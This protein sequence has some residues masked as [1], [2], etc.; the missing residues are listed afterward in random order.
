M[1]TGF[2]PEC[3]GKY[4]RQSKKVSATFSKLP[5]PRQWRIAKII[6]LKKPNKDN[7]TQAK[8]WRP[9]SLL[10]TVGKLLEAVIAERISFAVETHG[11]LPTNHFGARKQ[12]SAEQALLL[13]QEHIY[14]AWRGKNVLSLLSFDVKGAYNGVCKDSLL[15]RLVA[16][17]IPPDVVN[18][19]D[20]FC[21]ER[22]ATIVVNGRTSELSGLEQAGL[23]QG[24]P[25]SPILVL[26][27]NADLVQAQRPSSIIIGQVASVQEFQVT[28]AKDRRERSSCT[29]EGARRAIQLY[30]SAPWDARLNVMDSADNGVQAAAQAQQAKG[31]RSTTSASARNQ[32]VGIRGAIEGGGRISVDI[33]QREYDRTLGSSEQVNAHTAV[34]A[35]IALAAG[36]I[37]RAVDMGELSPGAD[38]GVIHV[39]TNDRTILATL[40]SPNRRS[41]QA[42][43]DKIL[44]RVNHL[45]E[46]GSRVIFAWAPVN[47]IFGLGQ[48]A[49]RLAQ[50]STGEG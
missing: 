1:K 41:G 15:Q 26:F 11:L 10:L 40:R 36:I 38:G 35:S 18:W 25:L 29:R 19:V 32:M 5:L 43:V 34:L 22:T 13:L 49:K 28:H 14:A 17:G 4:G 23:P 48:Q 30:V 24:S 20:S 8:A 50:Q 2:P 12:R 6:P 9:I 39:F 37:A 42:I 44:E 21:S 7:Y 31:I 45:K 16:R 27:F 46:F 33:E 3:G 47:S